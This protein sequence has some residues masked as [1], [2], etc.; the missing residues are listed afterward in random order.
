MKPTAAA[1]DMLKPIA[2]I[3][4]KPPAKAKGSDSMTIKVS[5][6]RRKFSHNSPKMMSSV[7][8]TT[9]RSRALARSRY[10]NCPLQR[11]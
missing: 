2:H 6:I 7:A 4:Q 8:G 5:E 10:S 9:M 3:S 1:T 11:T